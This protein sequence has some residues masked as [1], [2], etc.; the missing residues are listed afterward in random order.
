MRFSLAV[1]L[2]ASLTSPVLADTVVYVSLATP[3]KIAVYRQHDDGTLKHLADTDLPGEPGALVTDPERRFLFASLRAEGKLA[4]F[5]IDPGSGKLTPVSVVPA[6]PDPAHLATD[7]KGRFLLTAY[8]VAAKVTVHRITPK[9]ELSERPVQTVKT[10]DK[11]HAVV[12]DPSNRF[13]FVPHTGP[14][15]IF[16][17][18]F[19]ASTGRLTP[20][21]MPRLETPARTGPR[22]AVFHPS[23]AIA[24]VINEQ[25]SSVTAC[26]LDDRAGTLKPFQT[27]STLPKEFTDNNATA[28]I[29]IHPTGKFLYGSN[30]GHDSIALFALGERDGKLTA[31]GQEPTEKTPRSFDLDQVGKFLYAAGESSGKL[32][33]YRVDP[34]SGKLTRFATLNVGKTPWWVLAVALPRR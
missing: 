27:V 8:Y 34:K 12:P 14:N 30:R 17:F 13:V 21:T 9:G 4:S 31:Q 18:R 28:E 7:H 5:R 23:K 33:C 29:K 19:D 32:A 10:A 3:K 20:G 22:H 11:A 16:Q 15:V 26:A 2:L 25:G 6:G 1:V 24:Y